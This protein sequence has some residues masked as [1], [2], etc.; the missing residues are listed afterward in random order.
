[1]SAPSSQ[2]SQEKENAK[3]KDGSGNESGEW[4]ESDSGLLWV[5]GKKKGQDGEES[6]EEHIEIIPSSQEDEENF[7]KGGLYLFRLCP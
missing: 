6:D 3:A 5:I 1:V 2:S 7:T 4:E